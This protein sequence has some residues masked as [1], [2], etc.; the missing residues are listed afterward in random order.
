MRLQLALL[1]LAVIGLGVGIGWWIHPGAGLALGSIALG[2]VALYVDD[3]KPAI[4]PGEPK[5][6]RFW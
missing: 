4:P 6:G 2:V 3:G 1:L 5:K